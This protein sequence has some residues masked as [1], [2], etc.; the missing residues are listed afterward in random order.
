MN[1][2]GVALLIMAFS[3][4]E[5]L[6][7]AVKYGPLTAGTLT[8]SVAGT[9]PLGPDTAYHFVCELKSNPSYRFLFSVDDRLDSFA[10]TRDLV[11]LRTEKRVH[12]GAYRQILGADFDYGRGIVSYSDRSQYPLLPDSRDLLT[13]WYYFRTLPVKVGDDFDVQSHTDK[14]N[15]SFTV[16]VA[17][18]E[19]VVSPAGSFR[20]Y[21]LKPDVRSKGIFGKGGELIVY[22]SADAKKLPVVIKSKMFLGYLNAVLCSIR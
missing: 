21:V 16:K 10:R 8:L 18:T 4:G 17:D 9:V 13:L 15:Y 12:E 1:I 7:Y 6:A 11:T 3:P 22:L 5:Q 20:C 19:R 14:K 2:L